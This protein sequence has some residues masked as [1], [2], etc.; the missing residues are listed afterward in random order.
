VGVTSLLTSFS[1]TGEHCHNTSSETT[2]S[3]SNGL[4]GDSNRRVLQNP[5]KGFS[6]LVF[7]LLPNPSI[8]HLVAVILKYPRREES[9]RRKSLNPCPIA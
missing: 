5:H 4:R 2:Q 1:I 8:D 3:L 6:R 9:G 7:G